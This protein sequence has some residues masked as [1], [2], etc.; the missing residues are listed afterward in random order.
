[1][2]KRMI[3]RNYFGDPGIHLK[4]IP[5]TSV[6]HTKYTIQKGISSLYI[7]LFMQLQGLRMS[8]G[9]TARNTGNARGTLNM[10]VLP[11]A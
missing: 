6:A 9:F 1:M 11:A 3:I 8:N 10:G 4:C 2:A 7:E 5:W